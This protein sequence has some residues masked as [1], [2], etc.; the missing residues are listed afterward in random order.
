M[1]INVTRI[2]KMSDAAEPNDTR[3]AGL[4]EGTFFLY[5]LIYVFYSTVDLLGRSERAG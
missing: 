1:Q 3:E 5:T 2:R 4:N